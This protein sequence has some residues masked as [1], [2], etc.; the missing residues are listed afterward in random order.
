[1]CAPGNSESASD[2]FCRT[3]PTKF[4]NI[5]LYKEGISDF[6]SLL[7]GNHMKESPLFPNSPCHCAISNSGVT[8]M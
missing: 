8:I 1:M 3:S 4:I 5:L 2:Y 7:I 6:K